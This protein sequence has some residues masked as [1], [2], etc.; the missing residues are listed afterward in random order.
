[1][2]EE[3]EAK[4]YYNLYEDK[5]KADLYYLATENA[6]KGDEDDKKRS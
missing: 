4:D 1:M 5:E 3:K 6:I 2:E